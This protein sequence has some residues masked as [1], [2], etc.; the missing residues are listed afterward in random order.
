MKKVFIMV[1]INDIFNSN[2]K[3]FLIEKYVTFSCQTSYK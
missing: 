2:Q 1:G 3:T